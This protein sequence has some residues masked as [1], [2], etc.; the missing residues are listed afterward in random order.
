MRT[1]NVIIDGVDIF[2]AYQAIIVKD[3][4]RELFQWPTLKPVSGNDWQEED[5]FEPDLSDPRLD[6]R[7]MTITFGCNGESGN[8]DAFYDFLCSKP[9]MEYSFQNIG[10]SLTLRVV[11]MTSL[12][13]AKKFSIISVRFACDTPPADLSGL[14]SSGSNVEP[15]ELYV[16]DGRPISDYNI[17]ILE[18]TI[19]SAIGRPP[20]KPLLLR[21]TSTI[22][23]AEYDKNPTLYDDGEWVVS[24]EQGEVTFGARDITLRCQLVARS[25][26]EAWSYYYALLGALVRK[27]E[28]EPDPTLAG[29][30]NIVVRPIGEIYRCYYKSN[31]VEDYHIADNDVWIVFTLT[32]CLFE[33][34]GNCAIEDGLDY[35]Y[36]GGGSGGGGGGGTTRIKALASEDGKLIITEDGKVIRLTT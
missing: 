31:H 25:I 9:K 17:R 21:N 10:L 34:I 22:D 28:E 16:L 12:S 24:D 18:G 4:Y 27:D 1:S 7:E 33:L 13:Y 20:V 19:D 26:G 5:G 6:S 14:V 23:G 2:N 35:E 36:S 8:M 29:S 30:R 32:L 3:G 15:N 11:S